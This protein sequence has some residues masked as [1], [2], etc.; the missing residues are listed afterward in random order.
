[1]DSCD[2]LADQKRNGVDV[3]IRDILRS[4]VIAR[5]NVKKRICAVR[6]EP[7]TVE[8]FMFSTLSFWELVHLNLLNTFNNFLPFEFIVLS[9]DFDLFRLQKIVDSIALLVT[10]IFLLNSISRITESIPL[11]TK[12]LLLQMHKRFF[13]YITYNTICKAYFVHF[14]LISTFF[15]CFH[16]IPLPFEMFYNVDVFIRN[17][18]W[19]G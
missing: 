11:N 17:L 13:F 1:M 16:D 2:I 14:F 3:A 15:T 9:I 5:I 6:M 18:F 4:R 8:M 12:W 19:N 7:S 10:F